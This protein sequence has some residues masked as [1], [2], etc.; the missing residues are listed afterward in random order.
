ML[1]KDISN[2]SLLQGDKNLPNLATRNILT[3][4]SVKSILISLF[5]VIILTA[6]NAYLGLKVGIT[7]SA[8]IPAAILAMGILKLFNESNILE[9]NIIQTAASSGEA[10]AGG[11]ISILPSL[12]ILHYWSYFHYF[13]TVA[14]A[15]FGGT[16]G[17]IFSIPLRRVLF[18][19][20]TLSF[21][22]GVAIGNVLKMSADQ[23]TQSDL[24]YLILGGIGGGCL[25]LFQTGFKLF[26]DK[27]ELWTKFGS[28]IFGIGIGFNPALIA[29]GYIIV[30]SHYYDLY[31]HVSA[32][33]AVMAI[34]GQYIRYIGMG[35]MILGGAFTL[36]KLSQPWARGIKLLLSANLNKNKV[37]IVLSTEKDIPIKYIIAMGI[38]L[39]ISLF[40][41][42]IHFINYSVLNI[43]KNLYVSTIAVELI[44][45]LFAGF[46]FTSLC[47]YFTG[48]VGA[49]SNP[50]SGLLLSAILFISLIILYLFKGKYDLLPG[51]ST[52]LGFT[53]LAII[54][55]TII[56]SA[57][58]IAN[59]TI[60]DL[61]A[62][63]MIGATPWK[64][65]LMLII[66][67]VVA[68]L[69]IPPILQLLLNAYGISGMSN[70]HSIDSS[71]MLAAPT[72][73]MLSGFLQGIFMHKL[74]LPFILLGF[75][76]VLFC[77]VLDSM[78]KSKGMH[79][80]PLAV[81][82]G[83]YLPISSSTPIIIGGLCYFF[84]ERTQRFYYDQKLKNKHEVQ[85]SLHKGSLFA[86]GIVSGASIVG[87]LIAIPFA[88]A[89]SDNA[90]SLVTSNF[91]PLANILG[92]CA[93]MLLLWWFY[94]TVCNDQNK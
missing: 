53:V 2:Y 79:I 52:Q 4:I 29:A 92:V 82:L 84:I 11:I 58:S 54:P 51:S 90:L 83:I 31:Y 94:K 49:T 36:L 9:I 89:K 24:K 80:S 8:S 42:Y 1:D 62:G 45:T 93:T 47:G 87:V 16:L 55:T 68:S 56:A 73:T 86:C 27:I 78:V 76:I 67:V 3:E 88:I 48:L 72:A 35:V 50:I 41:L 39:I 66:G 30:I 26:S 59:D 91:T 17:V 15:L 19:E 57:M 13:E 12:L 22:E 28:S 81:G 23:E 44:Y 61:K 71:H 46:I 34:W 63:N 60:Q 75:G 10:L 7:I 25:N 40:F 14:I 85:Q 21:P 77:V 33:D 37:K 70:D 5:L 20:K 32:N 6:S 43:S 38:L 74:L 64:Q 18:A 65:Q 69:I